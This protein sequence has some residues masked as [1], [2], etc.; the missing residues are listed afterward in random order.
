M[1]LAVIGAGLI[2]SAA[3]RHLAR[4]SA[5]VT[6]IGPLEPVDRATHDGVFGSHYDEGRITRGLDPMP[7]WSRASRAS[8]ARY[9]EIE[10]A[11]G[12]RFYSPV[13]CLMA[14]PAGSPKMED[15]GR[16]AE[17]DG[18]PCET[19][20]HAALAARF[21]WFAFP[22]DTLG[23]FE[24]TDAGHISPRALVAAQIAAATRA[25]AVHLA[26]EVL[27]L[28]ETANGVDL[29]T[30]TRTLT[31]DRVLIATGG[32][33]RLLIGDALPITVYAR[34]VALFALPQAEAARLAAMPSMIW[35]DP[36]GDNPY[37]LPPIRYPDGTVCVKMGWDPADRDL[38]TREDL[39]DWFRSDGDAEAGRRIDAMI[40]ARIPGL[41]VERMRTLPCVTTY[42]PDQL[43]HLTSL[44]ERVHTAIGG[45]G[46]AAKNSD[47]LGRFGGLIL[48]GAALP[49]WAAEALG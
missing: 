28:D 15:I 34:T 47:E 31:F 8:I 9:A 39:T 11:S 42:T 29:R 20:D 35:Q 19:L 23:R 21:P 45:C 33:S 17:R 24:A 25:G 46:R 36:E 5:D 37:L 7:F 38:L 41:A 44:S 48:T 1:K 27:G 30:A 4:S 6:L 32:F 40:R 16:V 22:A 43:P 14:G 13:G 2:G 3:A 12:I 26:E 49:D 18:I 10:A